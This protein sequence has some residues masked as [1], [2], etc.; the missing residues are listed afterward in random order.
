M[1]AKAAGPMPRPRARNA[2]AAD[3]RKYRL[4]EALN[5]AF[6]FMTCP[7]LQLVVIRGTR[8]TAHDVAPARDHQSPLSSRAGR[9]A[10]AIWRFKSDPVKRAD[11]LPDHRKRLARRAGCSAPA[12]F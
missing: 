9:Y 12:A 5:R 3:L 1:S 11:P 6:V 8:R 2:A 4:L 10:P 7:S